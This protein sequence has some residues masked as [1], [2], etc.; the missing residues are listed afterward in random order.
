MNK[1][2][3]NVKVLG[4]ELVV[5]STDSGSNSRRVKS[6]ETSMAIINLIAN[7]DFTLTELAAELDMAKATV[8]NHVTTLQELG[9][10]V[11][12]G[13]RY[14][15]SLK[16]LKLGNIARNR[17]QFYAYAKQEADATMEETNER[18]LVMG[19][20]DDRGVYI[21]ET[22]GMQGIKTD[23][24]VGNEVDLH[25]TAVG[26][27]YLAEFDDDVVRQKVTQTGLPQFT[28]ETI[29]DIDKFLEELEKIRERG[30]AVNDEERIPGMRAVGS[31]IV[32]EDGEIL[33]SISISGPTTRVSDDAI[34]TEIADLV[35]ETA[36]VISLKMSYST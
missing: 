5:M 31:S 21:Y 24:K 12:E 3:P 29:T 33:G 19:V 9:Y 26:K 10:V 23:S 30:Y 18:C 4:I 34:M 7:D 28:D 6:V 22:K 11:R 17:Q 36:K 14:H 16:F 13:D 32:T 1:R 25:C 35:V 27:A 20:E 2:S 15:V 8:H